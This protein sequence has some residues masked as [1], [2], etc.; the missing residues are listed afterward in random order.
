MVE[1]NVNKNPPPYQYWLVPNEVFVH[2]ILH[3]MPKHPEKLFLKFDPDRKDSAKDHVKKFLLPV[4]LQKFSMRILFV[5]CSPLHLRIK[6][7][8]GSS[9]YRK[10][11]LLVGELFRPFF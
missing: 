11:P 9:L 3:D 7:Q 8:H 1:D 5:I 2:G 6:L 10:N 4:R